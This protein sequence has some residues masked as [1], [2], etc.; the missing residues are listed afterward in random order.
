MEEL[1]PISEFNFN[2]AKFNELDE[3]RMASV[4]KEMQKKMEFYDAMIGMTGFVI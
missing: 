4:E 1:N 2:L 3:R